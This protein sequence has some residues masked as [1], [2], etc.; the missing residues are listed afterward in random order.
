[1]ARK[2]SS[3]QGKAE[4]ITVRL[5]PKTRYGLELLARKQRRNLSSVV[6]WAL[7]KAINDPDQGLIEK[8]V[9][10]GQDLNYLNMLWDV[11]E[12]DRHYLMA[13]WRQDWLTFEEEKLIK[14]VIESEYFS[15][16]QEQFKHLIDKDTG[17]PTLEHH[18]K[19]KTS[20]R[21][22]FETYKKVASGELTK[23]HLP[24]PPRTRSSKTGKQGN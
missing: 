4:S 23:D 19:M 24:K 11:E 1:M 17:K 13:V 3:T 15:H 12:A 21:D 16:L 6:E 7:Q 8:S 5:D 22:H 20:L 18:Q 10:N 14:V 2:S 9:I